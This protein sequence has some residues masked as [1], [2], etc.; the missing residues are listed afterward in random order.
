MSLGPDTMVAHYR[1]VEKIGEGGMGVVW[2]ALDTKLSRH[3]AL[4]FLPARVTGDEERRLRFLR[5]AQAVA[6]LDH[7]AI[8]VIYETGEHDGGPF[9]SMQHVTGRSLRERLRDG[10]LSAGEWSRIAVSIAEGLAHAHAKGIIHRDLKP[11]N[12]MITDEGQVK[13]LDFGLARILE[14]ETAP[15]PADDDLSRLQTI[16]RE[17]TRAGTVLGTAAYMS[18]EQARAKSADHRSDLFSLGVMLYEM[19]CGERPFGKDT[20]VETLAAILNQEPTLLV[21]RAEVPGECGR[22]VHKLLEKEPARRY[23]SAADLVADLSN[24]RRDLDSGR[25]SLSAD[26][27]P[28]SA[29]RDPR[30]WRY[31][32]GG[33]VVIALL[34]VGIT[35]VRQRGASAPSPA[36][37]SSSPVAR[38]PL[39]VVGFENVTDPADGEHLGRA[40]MGLVTT[41]LAERGGLEVVSTSKI[42]AAMKAAGMAAGDPFDAAVAPTVASQT[43]AAVM[44]VGQVTKVGDR[45]LLTA[46]IVDV[47]SGNT[48]DSLREE[49][50]SSSELFDLAGTIARGVR[51]RLGAASVKHGGED[52]GLVRALTSSQVAYRRFV[53]GELL[54]NQG[55]WGPAEESF[56]A[57]I[58]EDP[59]FALAYYKRAI[60]YWWLHRQADAAKS[61]K[62]GLEHARRLPRRW[63]TLFRAFLDIF[64]GDRD[65]AYRSLTELVESS[66]DLADAYYLLGEMAWHLSRYE[67][68]SKA[69]SLLERGLEIDPGLRVVAFHM[70]DACLE[71]G[72]VP[73]LRELAVRLEKSDP[74]SPVIDYAEEALARAEGRTQTAIENAKKL[75]SQVGLTGWHIGMDAAISSGQ[76]EQAREIVELRVATEGR[77]TGEMGLWK[78]SLWLASGRLAEALPQLEA[79]ARAFAPDDA[80]APSWNEDQIAE[81]RVATAAVRRM[82]GSEAEAIRTL[83]AAVADNP[84]AP[85][86]RYELGCMLLDAQEMDEAEKTRDDLRRMSTEGQSPI[87]AFNSLLLDARWFLAQDDLEGA[88]R[89]MRKIAELDAASREPVQEAEVRAM[90]LAAK[91]DLGRAAAA[92]EAVLDPRSP[93]RSWSLGTIIRWTLGHHALARIEEAAG[94]LPAARVRYEDFLAR[95]GNADLEIPEVNDARRR[96]AALGSSR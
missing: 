60:A 42:L 69:E 10:R 50:G 31:L 30:R 52:F 65:R 74:A 47:A 66:S 54:L 33:V 84:W 20:D 39:A 85:L 13:I 46:E 11:D 93:Q 35:V 76:F 55:N 67:D 32:I 7:P 96:L 64:E 18:P 19:A 38:G 1:L 34:A 80:E 95:W 88:S 94:D 25:V 2:K 5:E 4:K 40:L 79:T 6:A 27:T 37:V 82:Q 58:R 59:T 73:R 22:I 9:L 45:I 44:L 15:A 14:G 43:G 62:E 53:E 63:Q 90:L 75:A 26:P 8:A 49:A 36:S 21:E 89:A 70:I 81:V 56:A 87:A 61:L 28:R 3:V 16:S 24:L 12:V 48:L 68:P 17:L 23:Q 83:R 77:Q 57:A 72:D 78:S 92:W 91:G 51:D 29:A 86:P 71:A 41:D